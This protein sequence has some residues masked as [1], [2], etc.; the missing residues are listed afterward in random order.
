MDNG[1]EMV[2]SPVRLRYLANCLDDIG[3]EGEASGARHGRQMEDAAQGW[4][5]SS[6][7]ALRDFIDSCHDRDR[8]ISAAINH[9]G[10]QVWKHAAAMSELDDE[11][12][13]DISRVAD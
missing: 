7:H 13:R 3:R 11:K 8:S 1:Q 6:S 10:T 2:V 9:V 12:A 4:V 5:G